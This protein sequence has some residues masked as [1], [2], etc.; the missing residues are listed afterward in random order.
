MT[1]ERDVWGR[2][3]LERHTGW[4]QGETKG[5]E[6]RGSKDEDGDMEQNR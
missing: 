2:L 6:E 4:L 5:D 1:D 3:V